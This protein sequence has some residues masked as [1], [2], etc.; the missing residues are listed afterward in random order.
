MQ[1]WSVLILD[2][3]WQLSGQGL[4]RL[5]G[6]P[7]RRPHESRYTPCHTTTTTTLPVPQAIGFL[8]F[9]RVHHRTRK[10]THLRSGYVRH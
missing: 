1:H 9:N 8:H 4:D 2:A 5:L 3:L 10:I 7:T 6:V